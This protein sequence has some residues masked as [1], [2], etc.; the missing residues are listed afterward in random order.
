MTPASWTRIRV[1]LGKE[2]V[3]FLNNR[4]LLLT[5]VLTPLL[6]LGTSLSMVFAMEDAAEVENYPEDMEELVGLIGERAELLSHSADVTAIY[7]GELGLM[8]M[9]VLPCAVPPLLAATSI[10]REKQ[11]RCLES[12]LTTPLRTWELVLTKQVF[13]LLVGLVPTLVGILVMY[14][15][16]HSQA[17]DL[18][19]SMLASG[20]WL[21]TFALTTP[22]FAVLA[23]SMA[24]AISSRAKDVQSAQQL[25][26]LVCLP[27]TGLMTLQATGLATLSTTSAL[28]MAAIV[29]PISVLS[30][31]FSVSLFERETVLTRWH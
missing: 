24:L 28:A 26:G 29:A 5:G 4:M 17:S 2:W 19:F 7:L 8:M 31:A 10:V 14:A 23:T 3:E 11:S 22:L 30:V 27:V 6:L 9:L 15:C 16:I 21:I 18:A 1:L 25:A 13:S 12:L 20:G